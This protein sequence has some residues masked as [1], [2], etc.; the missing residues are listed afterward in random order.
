M[1]PSAARSPVAASADPGRGGRTG[2][3][4]LVGDPADGP[5]L[6]RG[7]EDTGPLDK[8]SPSGA[9]DGEP[10][11]PIPLRVLARR[12]SLRPGARCIMTVMTEVTR[13]LEQIQE[14]DPRAA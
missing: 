13:I 7:R 12:L 10:S 2:D 14:G 5:A 1:H 8:R 3:I 11:G 6:R 4:D 9:D